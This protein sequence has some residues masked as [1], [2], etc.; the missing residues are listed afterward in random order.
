MVRDFYRAHLFGASPEL[1]LKR[2]KSHSSYYDPEMLEALED[3]M[4]D[5]EQTME[6]EEKMVK[7]I[8]LRPRTITLSD[9]IAADKTE[10]VLVKK[11]VVLT[12]SLIARIKN[13]AKIDGVRQ[14]I[15]VGVEKRG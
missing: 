14:P 4:D 12:R 8:D 15:H 1:A 9:V 13:I 7:I 2:L 6:F 3:C 11:G 10:R 5:A